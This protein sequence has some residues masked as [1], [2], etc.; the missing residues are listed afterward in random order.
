MRRRKFTGKH[1]AYVD[2]LQ[3]SMKQLMAEALTAT[4]EVYRT[5]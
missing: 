5:L 1:G 3:Q 4:S 2:W